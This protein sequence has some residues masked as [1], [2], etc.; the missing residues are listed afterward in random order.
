MK[1]SKELKE[2]DLL[3]KLLLPGK[4]TLPRLTLL[5]AE[6]EQ[7]TGSC[8][9]SSFAAAQARLGG[10]SRGNHQLYVPHKCTHSLGVSHVTLTPSAS[11]ATRC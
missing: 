6:Q 10:Q 5:Q 8:T 11:Q 4:A 7:S 1:R 2:E 9:C 3:S